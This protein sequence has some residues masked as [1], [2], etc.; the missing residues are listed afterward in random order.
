MYPQGGIKK[1]DLSHDFLLQPPLYFAKN[2]PITINRNKLMNYNSTL[3]LA[4][5][6]FENSLEKDVQYRQKQENERQENMEAQ[7]QCHSLIQLKQKQNRLILGRI[8]NEQS[9]G[10]RQRKINEKNNL[11]A[12]NG[13]RGL[14]GP[15]ETEENIVSKKL[16]KEKT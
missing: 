9:E 1:T 5:A 12:L 8:L 3:E 10:D 7:N 6:R 4:R 15:E 11:Y 14:Y 13:T 16:Y 2:I